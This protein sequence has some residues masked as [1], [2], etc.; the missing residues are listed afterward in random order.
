[1]VEVCLIINSVIDS[2]MK[3]IFLLKLVE[4]FILTFSTSLNYIDLSC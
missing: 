4:L 1:M 2:K 3:D